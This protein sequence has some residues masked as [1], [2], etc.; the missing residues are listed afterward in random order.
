MLGVPK[1]NSETEG[2]MPHVIVHFDP[3]QIEQ[4]T[5]DE[6]K[7][8]LPPI[9]AEA[10]SS[11]STLSNTADPNFLAPSISSNQVYV[12]QHA[13]HPTDM[14]P[15]PVEIVVKTGKSQNRDVRKVREFIVKEVRGANLVPEHLLGDDNACVWA[16][17]GGEDSFGFIPK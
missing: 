5:I 12:G 8:A 7:K 11:T 2:N 6:L 13:A 9:V 10:L 4:Q 3:A 15:A 14:Y 16:L 1:I 17:L